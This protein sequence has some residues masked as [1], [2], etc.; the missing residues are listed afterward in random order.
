MGSAYSGSTY[1]E[2]INCELLPFISGIGA[3]AGMVMMGHITMTSIDPG[4]PACLSESIV[5]G[6]LREDLGFDGVIITDSLEM[7]AMAGYAPETAAVM[8]VK[9]GV[10]ILLSPGTWAAQYGPSWKRYRGKDQ[11]ERDEDNPSQA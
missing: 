6:I 7:K 8:A 9:A 5:T 1:E 3:G 10:D 2:L 4:V 11:R